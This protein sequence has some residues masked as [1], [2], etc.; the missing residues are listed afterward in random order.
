MFYS[1]Y[2]IYGAKYTKKDIKI[3]QFKTGDIGTVFIFSLYTKNNKK[4]KFDIIFA[5]YFVSF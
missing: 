2:K 5:I 1:N 3:F 4:Y